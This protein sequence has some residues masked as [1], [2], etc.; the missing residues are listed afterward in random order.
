MQMRSK[1]FSCVAHRLWMLVFAFSVGL[2]MLAQDFSGIRR[3]VAR[4]FPT[5]AERVDF[6]AISADSQG[7]E[8]FR[9]WTKDARLH[10]E[11]SSLSAAS[12][13]VL[14]YLNTYCHQS[15]SHCG[16]NLAPIAKLSEVKRPTM[17]ASPFVYRYALNYCTYNYSYAFY[18]WKDWEW[19]L[20]WMAL[21]G[22]NLMLAPLGTE[23]VWLETLQAMG[24][25]EAEI[26]RFI[27]GPGFTAWWLMGNLEGWGG[28]MSHRMMLDRCTL[29]QKILR[30]MAELGITPVMQGFFGMVPR[31]LKT[32]KPDA[33]I[34]DQGRWDKF[35]RPAVLLPGNAVFDRM[36]RTYY[37][38]MRRHYG[39]GLKFF[40]GDLFHEGGKTDGMDVTRTATLVQQTML[41][42]V[43]DAV[44]LLQGW[45]NNP[46]RALVDGLDKHHTLI[47][48][49]AGEIT[50][51]WEA[52]DEFYHTPW[53]WGSVNHFGGKTDM[54]GQLPVLVSEPH[55]A[56]AE[57]RDSLMRGVGILP[58][59]IGTN[60]IVYDL[61]LKTAWKD[62][63]PNLDSLL[64]DYVFYRYGRWNDDV[65]QAWKLLARSVYGEFKIKGEGTFES[66]FCARPSLHVTSVSTWG[67]KQMQYDPQML[68]Q[69]LVKMRR[70]ADQF[71]RSETFRYDLVD[72][73]R[74]VLANHARDAYRQSVR[75]FNDSNRQELHR[76]SSEFM[77]LLDLQDR[78]LATDSHFLL[79]RWLAQAS[80][81]GAT[82][83]D[84]Q[85][86]EHNARVQITYWGPD[87]HETRIHD[88]A[89]KEWSGLLRDYYL[90]R[91]K[92]FYTDLENRLEGRHSSPVDY[93]AM[94]KSWTECHNVYPISPQ[95]DFRKMVDEVIKNAYLPYKQ[96]SL[97]AQLRANDLVRRMSLREKLAQMRHIHV[98][99]FDADGRV[100]LS[101]LTSSRTGGMSFGCMEAFPYSSE[102]YLRAVYTIQKAMRED[103][104]WG[105]P[106][107]PV[108][109]GLHGVVQDGCTIFPQT[110]AQAAT[111]NPS[112][113]RRMGEM[114][115]R[116]MRAIG[117]K[118]VLA[119]DL[120]IARE[121]RWGRV[122]E[123]FGEDPYLISRM[124]AAYVTGL[125]SEGVIPTLKHFTA[126]GTPTGGLNLASVHGGRRELLDLYVKP[127]AHVI[128]TTGAL[129]VMN[130]YSS[131]D[132]EAITAS[133]YYL[134]DLLRDSLGFRGYVYSDWGSIPMLRYFHRTAAS[135][136]DAARQAITAGVDLEAGSD[137]YRTAEQLVREGQ[138]DSALI[139]RSV[140]R[141]LYTKF[142]SGLFD[143]ALPDTVGWQK[144]IHTPEAIQTAK[145]IADES[146]VLLE[147]RHGILPL[148]PDRL[149]SVAVIGPNADRVQ[150]G[151][152]SWSQDNR[153]GITPLSG[154][155]QLIGDRVTI[156][157]AQ[158]CDLYSQDT[159]GFDKA[160]KAARQS[161]ISIIV[162]GTQSALLA[163]PTL[164]AT[165]GEGY[166]LSDLR[167]PGVQQQLI[168]AVARLNKPFIVVL[169][170]GRPLIVE[171]FRNTASAL[172][173]QWYGGEQA[174]LSLAET[175]FG[176]LNPSG[177]LPVSF[178]KSNGQ[179]PVFYNYLPTDK[180]YYNK[181]GKLD[182][183]GRD[184]VFSDPYPAYAFGHGLTYTQ[185]HYDQLQVASRLAVSGDT[186]NIKFTLTNIGPRR[187]KE[188]AQLYVR[189]LVSSVA[190]PIK[191]LYDFEKVDLAPHESREIQFRLPICDLALHDR[192]LRN[193]VEA[194]D[195]EIQI[196]ESS[197]HILLR[198][199]LRVTD[200]RTMHTSTPAHSP[201]I[202]MQVGAEITVSG[203][204][205]DVQASVMPHVKV[206]SQLGAR[207][208]FTDRNGH[209]RIATRIG[210]RLRF[211]LKG[212]KTVDLL[213]TADTLPDIEMMSDIE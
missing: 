160:V 113:I 211:T 100:D 187:G 191:Q 169:V 179:T 44:W 206:T 157:Y 38:S 104:R 95:G 186:I 136:A 64:H 10:I 29:Q 57:S 85:R 56:L 46:K 74:Q 172:L 39:N 102:Q 23:I 141:I 15:I 150:F 143:E 163:R 87:N 33:P 89:N 168:E 213:I 21:N 208:V 115:G 184:Y 212:Y 45:N 131:Y 156:R 60:P 142:A 182:N 93:F 14:Y 13:A 76:S 88:Y 144:H 80:R 175:L 167:L 81:Y 98:K 190:T 188:T 123:T 128:R 71:A 162:V 73:A 16:N 68:V 126:H 116:E 201:S 97:S 165:S 106:V 152:Y 84:R 99:H 125:Q 51:T 59:G 140:Q 70:A 155:R 154:I 197:D 2:P 101:K 78:L 90:P 42:N 146:I 202:A 174:G 178:P 158:G 86:S 79:G 94:E 19:E 137:Y 17:I 65:Y 124:G 185:F 147:N 138:L 11:A 193:V 72:L 177:K 181:K 210:D 53:I 30:R 5:L 25:S 107:I 62:K 130:C 6:R 47:V 22:I 12:S 103:T 50:S 31:A 205:R 34:V 49:L 207:S 1:S 122:E 121:L 83:A 37:E 61:A 194:G 200:D 26:A 18:D 118:Q 199:T 96:A 110:I 111:F 9:L 132:Q 67:P 196:G 55:R 127:F 145:A 198:D 129:S 120:D 32:H 209:Y 135:E 176:H 105:I 66:V 119:P 24:F 75:A 52:T 114:I 149:R 148:S 151:D 173:I 41:R 139:D 183:P 92:A 54:G 77:R 161:D 63:A 192:N 203:I 69:A 108:M 134:T 91:W 166:D 40:G 109:E 82:P 35:D 36:A 159:K 170:T 195:F 20:D 4:R 204:V 112:L 133:P 28:P 43:P 27:P 171:S 117:A 7:H 8:R 164:P 58:E 189:D 3:M 48:N 153:D 180:G